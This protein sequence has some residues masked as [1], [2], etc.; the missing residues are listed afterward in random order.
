MG[1][2]E[3]FEKF[4]KRKLMR[5]LLKFILKKLILKF[6]NIFFDKVHLK[7]SYASFNK[8]LLHERGFVGCV[9]DIYMV[10]EL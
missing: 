4:I 6:D 9:F 7:S 10:Y 2:T 8:T 1:F 5:N 3:I